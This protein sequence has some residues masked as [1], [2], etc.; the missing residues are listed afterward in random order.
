MPHLPNLCGIVLPILDYVHVS[1]EMFFED[2]VR[3]AHDDTAA[4]NN[5]A[6]AGIIESTER[7]ELI[8]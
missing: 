3:I 4:A 5:E 2:Q 1:S 6:F 8:S 7:G